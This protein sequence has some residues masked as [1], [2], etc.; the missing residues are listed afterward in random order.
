MSFIDELFTSLDMY[1]AT[2]EALKFIDQGQL[3]EVLST[4]SDHPLRWML[5]G[6]SKPCSPEALVLGNT[7][8]AIRE[9]FKAEN[10]E[11]WFKNRMREASRTPE[12]DTDRYDVLATVYKALAEIRAVG[13]LLQCSFD[14]TPHSSEGFDLTIRTAD[15]EIAVEVS[16]VRM[17]KPEAEKLAQFRSGK[18]PGFREEV[19]QPAGA[20]KTGELQVDNIAHKFSQKAEEENRQLPYDSPSLIWLDLQFEDWWS[21]PA[22]EAWPLYV[23]SDG[24]FRTG[25]VWLGFY[26][27]NGISL[28]DGESMCEG[29]PRSARGIQHERMR[30]D[31]YFYKSDARASGVIIVWPRCTILYEN[32]N[33][34]HEIP[35][36]VIHKILCLHHFDWPRSWV[37]PF[38]KSGAMLCLKHRVEQTWEMIDCIAEFANLDW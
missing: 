6:A 9:I 28:I 21:L 11:A 37:R 26:G 20:P 13:Y 17:S 14:V 2:K 19:I 31:G 10:L 29:L 16:A 8:M 25:G 15:E 4:G 18:T 3:E 35:E 23:L 7:E 38:W 34:R 5:K 27:R 1:P 30:Y 22:E 24:R 12:E 32:P 36:P 33:A